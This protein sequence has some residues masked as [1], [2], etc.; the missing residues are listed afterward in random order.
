[1]FTKVWHLTL[2]RDNLIHLPLKIHQSNSTEDDSGISYRHFPF[3][4][5]KRAAVLHN[6][7]RHK[8][9]SPSDIPQLMK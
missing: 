5:L 1:M 9:H 3:S 6:E 7:E 2:Y 8:L 4:Q